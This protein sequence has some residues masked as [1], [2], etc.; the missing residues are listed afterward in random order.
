MAT[1]KKFTEHDI[2]IGD[3]KIEYTASMINDFCKNG[4]KVIV[5]S[6]YIE[7]ARALSSKLEDHLIGLITGETPPDSRTAF[8]T[9]LEYSRGG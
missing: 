6:E 4:R 5:F 2:E 8:L 1:I 9:G 3:S 7:T